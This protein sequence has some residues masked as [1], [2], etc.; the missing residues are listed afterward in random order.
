MSNTIPLIFRQ[1]DAQFTHG[2]R[3]YFGYWDVGVTEA[4][5]GAFAVRFGRANGKMDGIASWH[6]HETQFRL[7]YIVRG[8]MDFEIEGVGRVRLEQGDGMYQAPGR[9]RE[10]G[11]SLDCLIMEVVA[12]AEFRTVGLPEPEVTQKEGTGRFESAVGSIMYEMN[13]P[14]SG[15]P[16]V[17]LHGLGGNRSLWE[18]Q[19][20]ALA[21]RFRVVTV[22]LPGHGGAGPLKPGASIGDVG[23]AVGAL[24]E[25]LGLQQVHMAGLS[26]GASVALAAVSKIPEKIRSLVLCS[27]AI[28]VPPEARGQWVA[29][30]DMALDNKEKLWAPVLS[31]WLSDGFASVHQDQVESLCQA[32]RQSDPGSYAEYCKSASTSDLRVHAAKVRVPVF[33]IT[34]NEDVLAGPPVA[35][36]IQELIAGSRVVEIPDARHLPNIEQEQ[37][38]NLLM[39]D[40]LNSQD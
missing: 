10:V 27:A 13:G 3:D 38:F 36:D 25:H 21:D 4:T 19:V 40:W 6:R 2:M 8:W 34:G 31:R 39:R 29:R 15:P 28:Y 33:I 9:H 23:Q 18:S 17:L 30:A 11:H 37:K 26:L 24:V 1:S 12:P 32:F 5:N 35:R 22:D 16:I 7:L 20:L 14:E